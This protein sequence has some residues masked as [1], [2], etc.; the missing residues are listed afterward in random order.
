MGGFV[1]YDAGSN[2]NHDDD[3]FQSWKKQLRKLHVVKIK[4]NIWSMHLN[5]TQDNPI[6]PPLAFLEAAK[7]KNTPITC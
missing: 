3:L 7:Y 6:I 5:T 2:G 1:S 4:P